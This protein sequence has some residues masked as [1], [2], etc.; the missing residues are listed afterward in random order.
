MDWK[1]VKEV[2]ALELDLKQ[3]D[4]HSAEILDIWLQRISNLSPYKDSINK[5]FED[6]KKRYNNLVHIER[7]YDFVLWRFFWHPLEHYPF[8]LV[9]DKY[10]RVIGWIA[11]KFHRKN[12]MLYGHIVDFIIS[13]EEM[14]KILIEQAVKYFAVCGVNVVSAWG[15]EA[16]RKRYEEMGFLEKGFT[17]N[18]GVKIFDD[19]LDG[20]IDLTDY[21]RWDMAM[22]YSD[23]F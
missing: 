9:K 22:S 5:I 2:R 8:F 12:E 16:T 18:F 3:T 4:I 17:T 13:D 14:E 21:N 19:R 15:N 1:L 7:S 6:S 11:L 23:A 20:L 10:G